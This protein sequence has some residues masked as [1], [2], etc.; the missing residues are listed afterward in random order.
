LTRRALACVRAATTPRS[1]EV[2]VARFDYAPMV[3]S[4]I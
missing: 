4:A 1:A 3:A 2:A